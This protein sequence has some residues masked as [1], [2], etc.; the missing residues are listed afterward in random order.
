MVILLLSTD[1]NGNLALTPNGT[2]DVQL[3]LLK[4][5]YGDSNADVTITTNGTGDLTLNTNA[6]SN[7]G[8]ITIADGTDGN[9]AITPNGTGEVD[10]SKVDIDGYSRCN[11]WC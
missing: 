1:T 9:I 5:V 4:Y 2:G 3:I 6:G 11:N 8:V 7:S 10:I